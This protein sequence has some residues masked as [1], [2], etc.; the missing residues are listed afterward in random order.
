MKFLF[1]S[2]GFKYTKKREIVYKTTINSKRHSSVDEIYLQVKKIDPQ[3]DA[4]SV[5]KTLKLLKLKNLIREINIGDRKNRYESSLDCAQHDHLICLDCG[6]VIEAADF[7]IEKLQLELCKNNHFFQSATSW[8]FLIPAL[9]TAK[10]KEPE[11]PS[12]FNRFLGRL[13]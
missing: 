4:V 3:F 13:L 2:N 7:K 9:Y 10:R 1:R 12:L 6:V 11:N 5:F 8:I